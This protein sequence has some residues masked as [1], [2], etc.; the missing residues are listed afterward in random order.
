MNIKIDIQL[1]CQAIIMF[2]LGINSLKLI[3]TTNGY[4]LENMLLVLL[5]I[6]YAWFER[7]KDGQI[8]SK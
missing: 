2:L 4:F 5:V 7:N 3:F 6:F 8:D 1:A